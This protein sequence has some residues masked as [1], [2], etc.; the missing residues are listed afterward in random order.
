MP[1]RLE[2]SGDEKAR[3]LLCR[4]FPPESVIERIEYLRSDDVLVF[5]YWEG[6]SDPLEKTGSTVLAVADA[7]R[8][9]LLYRD[10]LLR[11]SPPPVSP[12]FFVLESLLCYV[13]EHR[14]LTAVRLT[15]P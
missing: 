12:P 3:S 15:V 5:S 11:Q 1:E 13:R 2:A 7:A 8:G 6:G 4:H 9:T 14:T 10:V